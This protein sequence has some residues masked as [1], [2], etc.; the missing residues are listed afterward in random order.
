MV[1]SKLKR[2][3]ETK[4][5]FLTDK[6]IAYFQRMRDSNQK[7]QDRLLDCVKVSDKAMQASYLLAELIAKEK[8]PH[9]IAETL[10]LPACKKIVGVM[11][12]PDAANTLS[13]IPS[14]DNTIKRR[15]D[16][17]SEDIE[18]NLSEKLRMSGRFSLQIDEST[19]I[20][21]A[22]QLLANVR[23]V[24]GD[25]IKETFLF[26]KEMENHTTG[27]E[28]FRVTDNY[29]KEKSLTWD[30]C[31]SVCTD[32][33][34]CMTGRVRGFI[35]KVKTE[36][37]K[38][39]TNH[40]ILHR[41]ALVAKTMPPELAEV[42]DEAVQ[43]V[44]YIK[45]R[46]LKTRLFSQLSAEMG[47]DHQS[48][49][50]HTEVRWLS[51]GKVLSRLYELREEL[52]E[53]SNEHPVPHK[54]KLVDERWCAKLAYLADIFGHLN[55]L[56][57]KLQGRNENILSSTDKIRG[58][59]G[60]IT[61]WQEALKQG[62]M[63]MFPLASATPQTASAQSLYAAHLQTL[64]ERFERYFPDVADIEDCDWIRDPF[65]QESSTVKLP[66]KE[67]EECAELR[68]DRTMRLKFSELPLDQFWL[69][70]ASEYPLHATE[71][72]LLF[73]TT[74]LCEL[75]F[76][77]LVYMKSNRRSRLSVEQDL[78]VALSSIPPRIQ[79]I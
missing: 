54:Q 9:T 17:M 73:P 4:H 46:P 24:D 3:L 50:L 23:Y 44:N 20:S 77:T 6:N 2:H 79:K 15:I 66:M 45:S 10:I 61:L 36:N 14:S 30:M 59:M 12:G 27:E 29:L 16:D 39:V 76:S 7:Q 72:L 35:A 40:C 34:A 51:R 69:A 32:G 47:A 31:V 22:A 63:D 58:F 33:A 55:E 11:L 19:D 67:R 48:L 42:L 52:S 38:I 68:M 21:G 75:A 13:K 60:K 65:S 71:K 25:S 8:K 78:R 57:T 53:F 43:M 64:R 28:I 26:C 5:P 62:S 41:E 49:I 70:S 56:N 1:P 18:Q 74:Y 37:P